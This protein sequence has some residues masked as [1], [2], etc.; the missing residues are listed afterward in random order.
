MVN[1]IFAASLAMPLIVLAPSQS[2]AEGV[3]A[4]PS[5][6]SDVPAATGTLIAQSSTVD[7]LI[8]ENRELKLRLE[9]L[10][11]YAGL[12]P[13]APEPLLPKKGFFVQGDLGYQYRDTA[14]EDGN[15]VTSFQGGFYGSTGIGV[16][17][18]KN[19]RFSAEYS[20][21]S[22]NVNTV[23]SAFDTTR[24][25]P[26][27]GAI[28]LNEYT[29]NAYYDL[30]GFGYQKRWR[31]YVGVGVGTVKSSIIQLNNTQARS[32]NVPNAN[33]ET[34]APLVTFEGGMNYLVSKNTEVYLGAKYAL[35]SELLFLNTSFGNLLPQSARNW[36]LK[37]G[38][39]YTF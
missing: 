5:I 8:Q 29:A 32:F 30:D 35:G 3:T 2:K 4:A 37:T 17:V 25:Y 33:G 7:Q 15:T 23:S 21:L 11:K 38:I 20:N 9:R 18:N 22:S 36:I 12:N 26:G 28:V 19:F 13:K 10:E 1:K 27:F 16:R 39:R 14:G 6:A 24:N 31:P 34:W